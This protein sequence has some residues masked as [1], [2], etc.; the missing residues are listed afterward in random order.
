MDC[1]MPKRDGFEATRL[2]RNSSA[3]FCHVPII[4]LTASASERD[5]E[6][7]RLAGMNDFVSKPIR[8]ADLGSTLAKWI[9]QGTSGG[10]E[11]IQELEKPSVPPIVDPQQLEILRSLAGS[12]DRDFYRD[13]ATLFFSDVSE[14][15]LVLQAAVGGRAATTVAEVAHS[16][17][18]AAQNL[19]FSR[20]ARACQLIEAA[21]ISDDSLGSLVENLT[22]EIEIARRSVSPKKGRDALPLAS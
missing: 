10:A 14:R 16:I 20:V 7:C 6:Q 12:D 9:G 5:R 13:L 18:G 8:T 22:C 1:H 19:G 2:I 21:S 3:S 11:A 15:V 4:A 17:K